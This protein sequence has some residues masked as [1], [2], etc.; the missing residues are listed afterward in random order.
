M[1]KLFKTL[2][3]AGSI[4]AVSLSAQA[5]ACDAHGDGSKDE[6]TVSTESTTPTNKVSGTTGKKV[7]KA[8]AG[9]TAK[10]EA[11]SVE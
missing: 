11:K 1:S 7:A 6:S 3:I 8:K 5:F 10:D 9:E 2:L 4:V